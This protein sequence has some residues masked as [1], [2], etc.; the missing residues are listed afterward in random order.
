MSKQLQQTATKQPT[1]VTTPSTKTTKRRIKIS[2]IKI[3][4]SVS[5]GTVVETQY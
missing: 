4:A 5:L 3:L 2:Q 1:S